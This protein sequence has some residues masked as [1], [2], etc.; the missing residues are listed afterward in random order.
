LIRAALL[1]RFRPEGLTSRSG[2]RTTRCSVS[3]DKQRE[4]HQGVLVTH[5]TLGYGQ[6]CGSHPFW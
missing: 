4:A 1:I 6:A 2:G 3:S 5:Q